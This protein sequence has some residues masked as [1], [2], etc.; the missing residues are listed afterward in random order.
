MNTEVYTGKVAPDPEIPSELGVTGSLVARLCKSYDGKNHC[1]FTDRFYT[2]VTLAEYLLEKHRTRLCGT[3]LTNRKKF[4]TE[5]GSHSLLY[6]GNTAAVIWCD[7]KP[8]YFVSNKYINDADTTVLRYSANEHKRVPVSCPA[9][10]KAYNKYMGG[11]DKNDQMTKL[12]KCRRHYKWPRRLMVKFI[13]RCAFN[14]YIIQ[15]YYKP[16]ILPGKRIRS[17][18]MFVDEL[19]HDLVVSL[20]SQNKSRAFDARLLNEPNIP[21]HLP[22]RPEVATGNNRCVVCSEKYN[23]ARRVNPEA[24][25]KNLPKR[26]K[27]VY[28]CKSCGVFLCIAAGSGNCFEAY[29]SK[30]QYWR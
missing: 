18:R 24:K 15:N 1:I 30:V 4:P 7:K 27:T 20:A 26:S 6:S 12:Q 8:I 10:V 11:T 22:E 29:H 16:H 2:S 13:V 19:C 5:R 3:A 17:F 28:W 23:Q 9:L 25:H 14:A 21:L